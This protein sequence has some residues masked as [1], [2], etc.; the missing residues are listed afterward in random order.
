TQCLKGFQCRGARPQYWANVMIQWVSYTVTRQG[1][2]VV[3]IVIVTSRLRSARVNGKLGGIH[4]VPNSTTSGSLVDEAIATML[5]GM[6]SDLIGFITHLNSMD[7][8]G[9]YPPSSGRPK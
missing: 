7:R 2:M 3:L 5:I 6:P 8:G 1:D 9:R 4:A